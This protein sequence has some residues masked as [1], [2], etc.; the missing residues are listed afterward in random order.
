MAL[1]WAAA[2]FNFDQRLTE[3]EVVTSRC[4]GSK[5]SGSQQTVVLQIRQKKK[6]KKKNDMYDFPVHD[7]T[8]EQDGSPYVSTIVW[9]QM[10]VSVKK[11]WWS[12]EI[13]LPW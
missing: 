5:I 13:L 10:T 2:W 3:K 4:H 11:D 7:C 1:I 8:Q 12:P 6:T 9:Q